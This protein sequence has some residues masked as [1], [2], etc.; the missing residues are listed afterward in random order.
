MV[1]RIPKWLL[2]P[3]FTAWT[4][5]CALVTPHFE[6]PILSVAGIELA[7]GNLLQQNFLVK[8][9]V[10]NPNDRAL[11]ITGLHAELNVLGERV[12]SGVVDRA[13]V[14]P[15]QGSSQ[16]DMTISAN[17]ALVLLKLKRSTDQRS[18]D[19]DY[20]LTG[21]AGID[22]P[23]LREVPFQQRGVFSLKSLQ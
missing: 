11:P 22:L 13:F 17:L 18:D 14:V 8:F 21:A 2:L 10:R 5:A 6:K 12:A 3:L 9:N 7:G 15:A 4:A 23:F 20:E 1:P 16:F 19:I